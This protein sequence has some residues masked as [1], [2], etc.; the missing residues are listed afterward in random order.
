LR[1][2]FCFTSRQA[3]GNAERVN[4]Q[5]PLDFAQR[6]FCHRPADSTMIEQSGYVYILKSIK[7]D[8]YYI[9]SCINLEHRFKQHCNGL[10]KSTK[11][12]RPLQIVFYQKFDSIKTARKIELKLKKLKSRNIIERIIQDK[13]IKLN[14]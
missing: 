14:L 7:N 12:L 5:N 1:K 3:S 2:F 11:Y 13:I 8:S 10:V 4:R 9:G 6:K